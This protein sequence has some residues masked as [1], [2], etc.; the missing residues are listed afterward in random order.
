VT[1]DGSFVRL[2][3]ARVMVA[4]Y[5]WDG[6]RSARYGGCHRARWRGAGCCEPRSSVKSC[7]IGCSG[8]SGRNQVLAWLEMRQTKDMACVLC[9]SAD[10]LTSEDV[11]PHWL[12]RALK[13]ERGS[14]TVNV[15]EE[16]GP[17]REVWK[18]RDFQVTLDGGLC[19][20]CNNE[21]LGGLEQVVQPILEP[22][23]V[24]REL[25]VLDLASQRLLA[26]WAVKT[27]YLLELAGRQRYPGARPVEGYAPSIAELGW[28]LA[29]LEQ[30]PAKLIEPPP[31]SMVWLACWD[32]R[33]AGTVGR[34]SMVN[35]APSAAPLATPSG[36]EV[37]GQFT[38]LAIGFAV[39]QV[40]TVDYVEAEVRRA[41][42]WNPDPPDSIADGVRLI[43][44]HRLD[45]G[46]FTWPP[47]AFPND[48]FDRLANWDKALRRG[49]A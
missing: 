31:R 13:V 17:P 45:A 1:P 23:V 7:V 15:R 34:Q 21:R 35:Y 3:L 33:T 20:K 16:S 10:N 43:W 26:A 28:L 38:T 41:V 25:T 4:G 9:A 2:P 29:Q 5:S 22:M 49:V 8:F 37:V 42:V 39:F 30:R 14:T 24:R 19:S 6:T 18:L 40:L 48:S 46:D 11:I 47:P 12:L 36:G 44:P 32:C 27:V